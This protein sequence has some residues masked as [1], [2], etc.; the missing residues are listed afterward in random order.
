M[1][2]GEE[3][4][5][6]HVLV[7]LHTEVVVHPPVSD[8]QIEN[9]STAGSLQHLTH[10]NGGHILQPVHPDDTHCVVVPPVEASEVV[11]PAL[12]IQGSRNGPHRCP[13]VATGVGSPLL[14]P[15]VRVAA[16]ATAFAAA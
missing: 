4:L 12:Q 9:L 11:L 14:H 7:V 5:T 15:T 6:G 2:D 16:T 1:E 8:G 13:A 10:G 3:P